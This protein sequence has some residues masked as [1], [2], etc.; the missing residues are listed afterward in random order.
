MERQKKRWGLAVLVSVALVFVGLLGLSSSAWAT[1]AQRES[2]QD[3]VPPPV[4]TVDKET[5]SPGDEVVFETVF[6]SGAWNDVV[7]TD[8]IDPLLFVDQ[9]TVQCQPGPCPVGTTVA[10]AGQADGTVTVTFPTLPSSTIVTIHIH[11]TVLGVPP[12][13]FIE[14]VCCFTHDDG[15]GLCSEATI[16]FI[17]EEE[18]VP[19][20]GSLLLLVSGLTGLAGYAG[21]R[22][23]ASQGYADR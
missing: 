2:R 17:E 1:P 10:G 15:I 22:R 20:A 18:F 16:T 3:T 13:G 8:D 11:C 21:M 14:N 19:E 5:A 12:E 6:A 9:V 23:R 7:V 4:K